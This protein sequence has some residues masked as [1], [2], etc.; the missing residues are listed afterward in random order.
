M[1]IAVSGR[2]C[3]NGSGGFISPAN[4]NRFRVSSMP[5]MCEC[6]NVLGFGGVADW[7]A[8][9]VPRRRR[10]QRSR[11][12]GIT[13]LRLVQLVL[14]PAPPRSHIGPVDSIHVF[15]EKVTR[16]IRPGLVES[17]RVALA[18]RSDLREDH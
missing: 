14:E 16:S 17:A 1:P 18:S 5:T 3:A 2:K 11:F 15:H 6:R 7:G 4:S 10:R 12:D 9:A 13:T 8:M